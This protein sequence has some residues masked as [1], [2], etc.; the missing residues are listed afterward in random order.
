MRIRWAP[1]LVSGAGAQLL[2]GVT[3]VPP[4]LLVG[5]MGSLSLFLYVNRSVPGFRMTLLGLALNMVVIAANG[6]M[7]VSQHALRQIPLPE[8]PASDLRHAAAQ[9]DTHLSFLG[10]VIPVGERVVSVGDLVMLAGL[11][12]FLSVTSQ[13]LFRDPRSDQ[14]GGQISR[15]DVNDSARRP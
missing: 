2:L 7:P 3:S 5:S 14:S 9:P 13:R 15:F 10:D 4:W 6:A 1:L 11:L 12:W 8:V